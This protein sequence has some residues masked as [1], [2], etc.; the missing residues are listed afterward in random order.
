MTENFYSLQIQKQINLGLRL[1]KVEDVS[2]FRR[3]LKDNSDVREAF[4]Y[5][6]SITVDAII[7]EKYNDCV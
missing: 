5:L 4:L 1:F 3:L 7:R 2:G 6:I